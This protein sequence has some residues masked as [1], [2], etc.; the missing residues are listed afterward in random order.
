MVYI[1]SAAAAAAAGSA[2]AASA[3]AFVNGY[4][5]LKPNEFIR[6][7]SRSEGK[8]VVVLV[9]ERVGILNKKDTYVYVSKYGDMTVL[10]KSEMP[11]SLP[12]FT[13]VIIAESLILPPAVRTR[14]N[15]VCKQAEANEIKL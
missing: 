12:S 13:E 8:I 5:I 11:L 3:H 1:M 7:I 6:L 2:A 15:S 10:T 14:L 9:V 4:L